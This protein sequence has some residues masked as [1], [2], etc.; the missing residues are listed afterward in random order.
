MRRGLFGSFWG[1]IHF[2]GQ[3]VN[4][5][6]WHISYILKATNVMVHLRYLWA[7]L[8]NLMR[9]QWTYISTTS[10]IMSCWGEV[11]CLSLIVRMQLYPTA[12]VTKLQLLPDQFTEAYF[13]P[14][15]TTP[16]L[17]TNFTSLQS[18]QFPL[19]RT[20]FSSILLT[21]FSLFRNMQSF[22]T[23]SAEIF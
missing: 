1:E 16:C 7:F 8:V 5:R 11:P 4:L 23:R 6:P 15:F 20:V 22:N 10:E 18:F 19:H 9:P 17:F 14:I 12:A 3:T 2:P 21:A 13:P